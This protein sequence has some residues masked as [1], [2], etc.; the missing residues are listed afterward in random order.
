MRHSVSRD[1]P[2]LVA[3]GLKEAAEEP[4]GQFVWRGSRGL[5]I[6][7]GVPHCPPTSLSEAKSVPSP[8]TGV[9]NLG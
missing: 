2:V 6:S 5:E 1:Q 8:Q 7:L 4:T 3:P 9:T